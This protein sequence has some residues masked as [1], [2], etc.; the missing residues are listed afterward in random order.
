MAKITTLDGVTHDIEVG[1][2][3]RVTQDTGDSSDFTVTVSAR[4]SLESRHNFFGGHYIQSLEILKRDVKLPTKYGA[5]V[6]HPDADDWHPYTLVGGQWYEAAS[7]APTDEDDVRWFMQ[8]RG[9][10]VLYEGRG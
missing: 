7:N 6:G 9:F 2:K 3:V 8:N 5:V 4:G 1:D 10:V